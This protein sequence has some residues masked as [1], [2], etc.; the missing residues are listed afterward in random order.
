M[1]EFT[2]VKKGYDP[3]EVEKYLGQLERTIDE[4]KTRDAAISGAILNAQ[5]AADNIIRNAQIHAEE[6][7]QNAL[8]LLDEIHNSVQKQKLIVDNFKSE[9]TSL[10]N[11]YLINPNGQDFLDIFG[12]INDLE[13]Y[14]ASL[15]SLES[16]AEKAA[17][18]PAPVAPTPH[19]A[20]VQAATTLDDSAIPT[21]A[22][23]FEETKIFD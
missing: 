18:A 19:I 6:M 2:M 22:E 20:D 3:N 17:A 15:K 8:L 7:R 4:Y 12:R 9:Y 21:P 1:Q 13:N 16:P 5:I 23:A 10:V 11:K 14:I